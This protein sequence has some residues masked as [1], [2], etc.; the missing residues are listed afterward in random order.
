MNNGYEMRAALLEATERKRQGDAE[1][2]AAVR[3]AVED[4]LSG[5]VH[6]AEQAA[7]NRGAPYYAVARDVRKAREQKMRE[8]SLLA[9]VLK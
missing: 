2:A 1:R 8:T 3:R 4:V 9:G 6:S 7:R 5:A